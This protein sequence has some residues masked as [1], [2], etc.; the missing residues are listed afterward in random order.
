VIGTIAKQVAKPGR[1]DRSFPAIKTWRQVGSRSKIT[2]AEHHEQQRTPPPPRRGPP[3]PPLAPLFPPPP[4][5]TPP[6]PRPAPPPLFFPPLMDIPRRE[7]QFAFRRTHHRLSSHSWATKST[8]IPGVTGCS[9]DKT[10]L[11]LF[12]RFWAASKTYYTRL[13]EIAALGFPWFQNHLKQKWKTTK[14]H[15]PSCLHLG[16]HQMRTVEIY[17]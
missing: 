7:G 17:H 2:L 14:A 1:E 10:A 3:P 11:A 6:R 4:P 12:T 8:N 16:D 5:T 13:D 9:G 15:E